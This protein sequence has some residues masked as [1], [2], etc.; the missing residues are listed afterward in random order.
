VETGLLGAIHQLHR[1]KIKSTETYRV[2]HVKM[3]VKFTM[4]NIH[5]ELLFRY[6]CHYSQKPISAKKKG[7][8]CIFFTISRRAKVRYPVVVTPLAAHS[9][10]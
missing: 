2:F 4:R 1:W 5:K 9:P 6:L 3:Y 7:S 8:Y 10:C